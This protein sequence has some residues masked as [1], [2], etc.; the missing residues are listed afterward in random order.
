M[1]RSQYREMALLYDW[2]DALEFGRVM[3]RKTRG[4]LR[5]SGV[6]P[7]AR[8]CDLACGTGTL[9]LGLAEAGYRVTGVD[10]SRDMLRLARAKAHDAGKRVSWRCEDM[11]AFTLPHAMDAVT[12]YYD[13]I[14]H[15]L[16]QRDL[17]AGLRQVYA[18]LRPGGLFCFDANTLFCY[19]EFWGDLIH[20]MDHDGATQFTE[21]TFNAG[22][23]R[24][25]ATVTGFIPAGRDRYRKFVERVDERYYPAATWRRLLKRVGFRD[26]HMQEFDPW[27]HGGPARMKWFVTAV[28]P[29]D[30][31][32]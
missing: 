3:L 13:A 26:V 7:P 19:E 28:R 12:C 24:A 25:S 8:V 4:A 29:P 21:G 27:D 17:L 18:A 23:G 14:N 30:G 16:T 5:R 11:R 22:T 1:P 6:R 31:E 15:L 2:P 10:L 20:R 32:K 9:A